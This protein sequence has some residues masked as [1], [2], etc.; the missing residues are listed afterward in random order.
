MGLEVIALEGLGRAEA[1]DE[2]LRIAASMLHH[3]RLLKADRRRGNI[4]DLH[5]FT[6]V[7]APIV[8]LAAIRETRSASLHVITGKGRSNKPS[9]L[10]PLCQRAAQD[11]GAWVTVP[12]D[13]NE[14]WIKLYGHSRSM[15]REEGYALLRS[16]ITSFRR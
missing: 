4:L 2:A 10:H 12:N 15:S 14:G 5:K 16:I 8:L 6:R 7:S 3:R 9:V 13:G 1:F 11:L